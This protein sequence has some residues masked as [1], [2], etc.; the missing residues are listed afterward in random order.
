MVLIQRKATTRLVDARSYRVGKTGKCARRYALTL[1][2]LVISVPGFETVSAGLRPC[3]ALRS[4][5]ADLAKEMAK[6]C[7]WKPETVAQYRRMGG[8]N[9]EEAPNAAAVCEATYRTIAYNA[10][11]FHEAGKLKDFPKACRGG[12]ER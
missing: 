6:C 7:G 4:C 2:L 8:T 5:S 12:A 1:P 11:K 10:L 3:D 9:F